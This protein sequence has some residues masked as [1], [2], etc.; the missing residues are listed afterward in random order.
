METHIVTHKKI[1]PNK[2]VL[3][4]GLPGIGNVGKLVAEH[5]KR[6]FKAQRFATLYSPHFPHQVQMLKNGGVRL[7]SNRFYLIRDKRFKN[8]IM[9]LTGE[10]QA[11]SPEGQFEVNEKIVDFFKKLNGMFVYTLGGYNTELRPQENP[12]VYGNVTR[13]EVIKQFDGTGIIFGKSRGTI[14]G[15]AGLIIAFAKMAKM[16]GICI[17]GETAYPNFD[18]RAAK[19]VLEALSKALGVKI[20][21]KHLDKIID[22][23]AKA[24]KD[25]E[26]QAGLVIPQFGEPVPT[27]PPESPS[28]IR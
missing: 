15:S 12:Q 16:D 25:I 26:K 7:V 8:D 3:I 24:I 6:E 4:V 28:Y 10:T 17:M 13:K 19:V 20:D 1:K 9:L 2:P 23:T 11:V 18:P 22:R 21:T 5:L 14:L 27:I